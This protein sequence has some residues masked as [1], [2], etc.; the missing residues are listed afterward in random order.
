MPSA[1]LIRIDDLADPVLT[2]DERE[3]VATAAPVVLTPE[4]VLA[5]ARRRTGLSDFG[6]DD[7]RERLSVWTQ[8]FVEDAGLGPLGRA[9]A[10]AECVRYAV[11]RL[12]VEDYVARH[13]QVLE[14]PIDRPIIIA[15]LPRSGT[16]HLVNMLASD[17]RLRSLPLWESM[18]PVPPPEEE[19]GPPERSP[20]YLR[21]VEQWNVYVNVLSYMPAMHEM[22]PEHI[23][24]DGEL[25]GIDFASYNPEWRGRLPRWREYSYAHDQTPHYEYSRKVFQVLT[26]QRGPNRWVMKYPPHMENLRPLINTFPDATVVITHRDPVAVIQSA[27][28]MIAYWDRVRRT[29]LDLPG[30]ADS[31]VQRIEHM[32]RACVRDRD[33]LPQD[34][35]VDVLFH[36]YMADQRSMIERVYAAAKLPITSEA[37]ARISAYLAANPRG[38]HGTMVYDPIGQFGIDITAVRRRFEFYYERFGVRPEPVL[39][40]VS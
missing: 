15:G 18:E 14:V 27:I 6:A 23:H 3:A 29:E 34:Q 32:L 26:A 25:H 2:D 20:R 17:P 38:R 35:V 31:W 11:N 30:L 22:E 21:T 24:E 39:G 16:T 9:D 10:F 12:R 28:T 33:E 13:P 8:S 1:S 4:A 40:E 7:F 37:E 36:E 5:E 19:P